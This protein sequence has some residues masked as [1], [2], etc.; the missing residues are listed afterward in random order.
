MAR[1]IYSTPLDHSSSE[2]FQAW[3]TELYNELIAA[4]LVPTADTGQLPV[5]VAANRPGPSGVAGYW[6][7]RFND[8]LQGVA[9]IFLKIRPGTAGNSGNPQVR[10]ELGTG[11]DGA[12]NLTGSVGE[13]GIGATTTVGSHTTIYPTFI[14]HSDGFFGLVLKSGRSDVGCVMVCRTADDA[15]DPTPDGYVLIG[16]AQ[17]NGAGSGRGYSG[18]WGGFGVLDAGRN[19]CMVPMSMTQ[20]QVGDDYQAFKVYGAFPYI[21]LVPQLIVVI[22]GE[23]LLG[24]ETGPVEVMPGVSKSYLATGVGGSYCTTTSTSGYEFAMLWED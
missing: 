15:G 19:W 10:I 12:G 21:R 11:S 4:G 7:F 17:P 8:A 14:T 20:S 18:I 9:P 24:G 2:G 1:R 22:S 5:P 23:V 16:R 6:I 13:V 3:T